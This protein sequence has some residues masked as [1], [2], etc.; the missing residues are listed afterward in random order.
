MV[1]GAVVLVLTSVLWVAPAAA[2]VAPAPLNPPVLTLAS[3]VS[4]EPFPEQVMRPD[5]TAVITWGGAYDSTNNRSPVYACQLPAAASACSSLASPFLTS[6]GHPVFPII[7]DRSAPDSMYA[8]GGRGDSNGYAL[9]SSDGG[10]SF[11][12][13]L[14]GGV[15]PYSDL[16]SAVAGP[17]FSISSVSGRENFQALPLDGSGAG[18]KP[19]SL[20]SG[21]GFIWSTGVGMI[22]PT[23]PLV[24]AIQETAPNSGHNQIVFRHWTDSGDV[25][26]NATWTAPSVWN[27]PGGEPDPLTPIELLSGPK[28]LFAFFGQNTGTGVQ[29]VLSRYDPVGGG[30]VNPV[31]VAAG[32]YDDQGSYHSAA[33]TEDAAGV[34]HVLWRSA[35][36]DPN[37]PRGYY[38]TTSPDGGRTFQPP[39]YIYPESSLPTGIGFS[40][41]LSAD[42]AGDTLAVFGD[43]AVYA[44]RL[45]KSSGGGPGCQS[46]VSWGPLRALAT[47][48]CFTVSGSKASA[49]GPVRIDGIDLQPTSGGGNVTIDSHAHTVTTTGS[50][51]LRAGAVSLG[52]AKLNWQVPVGGGPLNDAKTGGPVMLDASAGGQK[53]L[54]M[55]VSGFVTP[56]FV[57]GIAHLPVNLKIPSPVGGF[58]GGPPIDDL[59]LTADNGSSIHLAKGGVKIQLPEVDLGLASL[60]PFD[61]TYTSDPFVFTGELGIDLPVVGRIDGNWLFRNGQFIDA[62]A[63]YTPP[64]PG[65]PITGFVYLT[66]L[67]LHVHG[68]HSCGDQTSVNVNGDLTAGPEIA[69]ESL[70]G[71]TNAGATYFLSDSS[72]SDP[73]KF[74]I[75]GDGRLVGIDALHLNLT[76]VVP[77]KVTFKVNGGIGNGDLGLFLDLEGGLDGSTGNFYASGKTQVKLLG[78]DAASM[79]LIVGSVGF[80]GCVTLAPI[81]QFWKG[82]SSSVAAGF[83][84]RWHGGMDVMVGDCAV[85]DLV[86]AEFISGGARAHVSAAG[87]PAPVARF[88]VPAGGG[89]ETIIARAAG[90]PPLIVLR[91]PHGEQ[92]SGPASADVMLH[93]AQATGI[94]VPGL[95]ETSITLNHPA[96]GIWTVENAGA[97]PVASV[98][99]GHAVPRASVHASV[100]HLRGTRFQLRYRVR[101][102]H[103][104]TVRFFQLGSR[105]ERLI[106][107]AHG[108]AGTISFG[109]GPG[110]AE[111]RQ[112][113]AVVEQSGIPRAKVTVASFRAPNTL[114]VGRP[115]RV[116]LTRTR[117]GLRV[118]W[119]AASGGVAHYAVRILLHDGR[120]PL[121][122]VSSRARSVF[123][124]NVPGID[125]GRVLVAAQGIDGRLGKPVTARFQKQKKKKP[126][127]RRCRR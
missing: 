60:K 29:Y 108:A 82:S 10:Q 19:T 24:A 6:Y 14:L 73:A 93:T 105:T 43:S 20:A 116:R 12:Q 124:N 62:T 17:A 64:A 26:D 58:L 7:P 49:S 98:S 34:V 3:S 55:P 8:F 48:G 112:V 56:S 31:P 107:R 86:P 103:G 109:A 67:G 110:V 113:I 87:D 44:F 96:A 95:R 57:A 68:G 99:F 90:G 61:I 91:G 50:W 28:G 101:A 126:C 121:Y 80:G 33:A 22:D 47:A 114:S 23:T 83:E 74:V 59:D 84:Y 18:V 30:F 127:R 16:D 4:S 69:G 45:P 122:L 46:T 125:F 11:S 71:L 119:A 85:D 106:G 89:K 94:Q 75:S 123:L 81:P 42:E 36:G 76:Y 13:R 35:T 118:S 15:D 111:R 54:G 97:A 79:D 120:G 77:A 115:Q 32:S 38:Y 88:R 40:L 117:G 100:R 21:T 2:S 63:N 66:R 52:K 102:I 9:V 72:C 5:G 65:I 27:P 104:Q 25:N 70:L 78:F 1:R 53:V 92:V 51:T 39:T 37:V 41:S